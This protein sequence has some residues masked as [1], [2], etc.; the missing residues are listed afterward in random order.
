MEV[1]EI[2]RVVLLVSRLVGDQPASEFVTALYRE[3]KAGKTIA[4][5]SRVAR[6]EARNA[7]DA[8][9]LAYTVY[10]HPQLRVDFA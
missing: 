5:A 10:A 4:Q 8:S 2:C 7:G 1:G 6:T 9:W 3:L